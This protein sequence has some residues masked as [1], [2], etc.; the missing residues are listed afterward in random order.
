MDAD[1]CNQYLELIPYSAFININKSET[2]EVRTL[3]SA[4]WIKGPSDTWDPVECKYIAKK[5][6]LKVAL[7]S[8]RSS[9]ALFLKEVIFNFFLKKFFS[10]RTEF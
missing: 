5:S 6:L 10:F 7:I 9:P 3:L 2:S 8:Y 4:D 1:E